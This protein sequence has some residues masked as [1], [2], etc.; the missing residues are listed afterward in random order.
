MNELYLNNSGSRNLIKSRTRKIKSIFSYFTILLIVFFG[1]VLLLNQVGYRPFKEF[2]LPPF[3]L[4]DNLDFSIKHI[5]TNGN[6][7]T[8]QSD[9]IDATSYSHMVL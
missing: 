8:R 7:H 5:S 4:S 1:F 2:N 3:F 9:I 6:R